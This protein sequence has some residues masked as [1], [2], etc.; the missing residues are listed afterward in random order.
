M[1]NQKDYQDRE[2][3]AELGTES[4][5]KTSHIQAVTAMIPSVLPFLGKSTQEDGEPAQAFLIWKT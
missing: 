1:A 4:Q 2:T 3:Q 5:K